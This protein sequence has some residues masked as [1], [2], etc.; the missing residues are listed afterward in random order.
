MAYAL[1]PVLAQTVAYTVAADT[2]E[3]PCSFAVRTEMAE[4]RKWKVST[5]VVDKMGVGKTVVSKA[6]VRKTEVRKTEVGE[7]HHMKE[8]EDRNKNFAVVFRLLS[9]RVDQRGQLE[10]HLEIEEL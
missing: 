7:E 8:A 9:V 10:Q 1:E 5:K 4:K 6:E 2:A 3:E